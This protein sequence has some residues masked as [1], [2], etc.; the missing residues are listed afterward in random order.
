MN[1]NKQTQSR[2]LLSS[3]YLRIKNLQLGYSLPASL[4]GKFNCQKLRMFINVENLATATKMI[5][6]MDPEFSNTL[7]FAH[8]PDGKVYPLQRTW[9]CGL[10]VTF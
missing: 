5:K 3:A 9:A 10:N 6:T 7:G 4:L 1:K 2:Y 8:G